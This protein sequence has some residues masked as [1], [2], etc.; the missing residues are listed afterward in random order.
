MYVA[1]LEFVGGMSNVADTNIAELATV[2]LGQAGK[3]DQLHSVNGWQYGISHRYKVQPQSMCI[4]VLF[5]RTEY[6]CIHIPSGLV[7]CQLYDCAVLYCSSHAV[8]C[9]LC[10]RTQ[11]THTR[12]HR[13][14]HTHT[15]T[16]TQA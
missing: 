1:W 6:L 13:Y 4:H 3:R 7:C 11:Y 16:H 9:R 2:V 5:V 14:T 10:A 15:H 12:T 8:G